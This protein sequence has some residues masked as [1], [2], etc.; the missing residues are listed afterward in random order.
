M[1]AAGFVFVVI[2]TFCLAL[3]A[4]AAVSDGPVVGW[5]FGGII[6]AV[7]AFAAFAMRR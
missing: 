3:A 4:L 2:A 1:R 6:A 7:L 5:L